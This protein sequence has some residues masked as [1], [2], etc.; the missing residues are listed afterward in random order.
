M[1]AP[2][3]AISHSSYFEGAV[4]SLGF[5]RNGRKA[6]VGVIVPGEY[7]FGTD[8]PERM[9]IISGQ[10]YVRMEGSDAWELYAA[11]SNFEVKGKSA[12]FVKAAAPCAYLCEY[13]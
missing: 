1:A 10:L 12:F 2:M 7:R 5:D 4:Q 6:T 3:A 13:L 11:G 8:S 9:A